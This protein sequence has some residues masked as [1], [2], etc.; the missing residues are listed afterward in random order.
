MYSHSD[1][2]NISGS[3]LKDKYFLFIMR[4]YMLYYFPNY[5]GDKY[6]INSKL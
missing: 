5:S 6:S 1:D 3:K 2:H 4:M